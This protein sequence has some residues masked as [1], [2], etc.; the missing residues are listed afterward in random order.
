M[1]SRSC[2]AFRWLPVPAAP[3]LLLHARCVRLAT[4]RTP[5]LASQ[6][7]A[8][9]KHHELARVQARV[10]RQTGTAAAAAAAAAGPG[11]LPGQ[12]AAAAASSCR[13]ATAAATA[14]AAAVAAGGVGGRDARNVTVLTDAD[15][16]G[17]KLQE[18]MAGGCGGCLLRAVVQLCGDVGQTSRPNIPPWRDMRQLSGDRLRRG[19]AWRGCCHFASQLPA[20]LPVCVCRDPRSSGE[21]AAAG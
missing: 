12:Q 9:L 21:A 3:T 10:R 18:L 4:S 8:A 17:E 2:R 13:G 7:E 19:S 15:M 1:V 6:L 5:E 11:H 16:A 14:A 20:V